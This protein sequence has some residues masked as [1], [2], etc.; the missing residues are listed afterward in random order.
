[1]R[2]AD[3]DEWLGVEWSRGW[4]DD[5]VLFSFDAFVYPVAG[6]VIVEDVTAGIEF[7]AVDAFETEPM[8]TYI[9]RGIIGD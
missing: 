8:H 2:Q 7:E 1:M 6:A 5:L 3:G 4:S 9:V